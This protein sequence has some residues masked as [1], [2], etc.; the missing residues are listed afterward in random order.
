MFIP[1][2]KL[3]HITF[4]A[5]THAIFFIISA[6]IIYFTVIAKLEYNIFI[7]FIVDGAR[8]YSLDKLQLQNNPNFPALMKTLKEEA[9]K[10]QESFKEHN[11]KLM[12][13]TIK[14]IAMVILAFI[15]YITIMPKLL[16]LKNSEMHYR[17]LIKETVLL[18]VIVGLFEYFFI[19]YVIMDYSFYSFDQFLRD[20]VTENKESIIKYLPSILLH[21]MVGIPGYDKYVPKY[22]KNQN[23]NIENE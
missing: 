20:Y 12:Y 8:K 21:F 22:L 23:K 16:G 1:L 3:Y 19:K 13:Q 14:I 17:K 6:S 4:S 11:R 7:D 5:G 10:E 15:V 2:D 9:H 18:L